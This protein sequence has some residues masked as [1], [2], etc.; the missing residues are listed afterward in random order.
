[1]NQKALSREP[2]V[3]GAT[4]FCWIYCS[5]VEF[6]Y[7]KTH[8]NENPPN[9]H[10]GVWIPFKNSSQFP[11]QNTNGAN[12]HLITNPQL[13]T[14][15]HRNKRKLN[16]KS[17]K[18]LTGR[19]LFAVEES[20]QRNISLESGILQPFILYPEEEQRPEASIGSE[21]SQQVHIREEF[22]DE[23]TQ[24]HLQNN[25]EDGFF[26]VPGSEERIPPYSG[27]QGVPKILKL[28][29]EW[30]T[31]PVQSITIW[32]ITVSA[33]FRKVLIPVLSWA[34]ERGIRVV[35]Y[36]KDP[37]I[38]GESKEKSSIQTT[39][40]QNKLAELGF[41]FYTEKSE[42]IP[43]NSIDRLRMNT[44]TRDISLNVPSS[45]VKG[46]RWVAEKLLDAGWKTLRG[47]ARFIGKAQ[48]MSVAILTGLFMLRRLL[49]LKKKMY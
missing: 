31:V 3:L 34:R 19:S 7:C 49:V 33:H 9:F 5:G 24:F 41:L 29:L 25:Q 2:K 15:T 32:P 21:K 10:I 22:Q 16:R 1:M 6:E 12:Q 36:L 46:L 28:R 14:N 20:D 45:K 4:T 39:V 47:L 44:N 37:L 35:P 43:R 23:F 48:A 40:I 26:D 11:E 42:I 17:S 27:T 30:P 13:K 18:A 38:I 8:I